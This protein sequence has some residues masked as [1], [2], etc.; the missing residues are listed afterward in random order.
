MTT[1]LVSLLPED[2][3]GFRAKLRVSREFDADAVIVT[4]YWSDPEEA[5][6]AA[7]MEAET[8]FGLDCSNYLTKRERAGVR[9]RMGLTETPQ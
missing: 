7:L 8:T 6:Y 2:P 4:G 9:R 3:E 5:F 1:A